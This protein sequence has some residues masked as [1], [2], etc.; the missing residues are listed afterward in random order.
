[1][2]DDYM[3]KMIEFACAVIVASIAS[4]ILVRE[5]CKPKK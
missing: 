5:L 3:L 4:F 1:M 2:Q